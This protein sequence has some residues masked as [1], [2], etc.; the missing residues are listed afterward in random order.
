[1]SVSCERNSAEELFHTTGL[2]SVGSKTSVTYYDMH[3]STQY[4][5]KVDRAS[6]ETLSYNRS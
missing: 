1:M 6:H 2:S 3:I 5:A 4:A